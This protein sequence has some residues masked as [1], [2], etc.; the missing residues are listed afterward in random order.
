[1]VLALMEIL[2]A[3]LIVA[4]ATQITAFDKET[5]TLPF[6]AVA[7]LIVFVVK[8]GVTLLDSYVQNSWIQSLILNFK[9]RL[10]TRYTEM[11]YAYQITLNSGRS[12]SVL[13]NDADIY[14]RIGLT[15][16]GIMLSEISV[17]LILIAYLLY[18]QPAI[19]A[20][21]LIMFLI[22]GG[23]FIL[24]LVPTFRKWGKTVQE[25]AQAGYQKALQILQ[26]YKDILIFG[27][28]N[29][30]ISLYMEQ[31]ILR[32][33]VTVKSAVAQV[34]PRACIEVIFVTF[35]AG[36]VMVFLWLDYDV[37]AL[38]TVLSAYLYAGFRLLPGLN[39]MIIQL[40]NVK[41]SEASIERIVLELKS[42][43]H[44]SVYL[45]A[46]KLTFKQAINVTDV[47]FSYPKKD[48]HVLHHIDLEIKKGEFIGIVGETGSGKSTLLH[49]LLGLLLPN[50]GTVL[51]DGKYPANSPEWHS[52]IGYAAQNFHLIEGS[53]VDNVAFGVP[54]DER[55][56]ELVYKVIKNAE[57][58][59]F[60][61]KLPD[62]LD[63]QIGEKGA[64]VSG[65]ERQRIALARALY[66]Q[67][68][69]LMLDEATSALDL[70]TEKSIMNTIEHLRKED[71]TI[72]AVTHRLDTLKAADR[73]IVVE[74]GSIAKEIHEKKRVVVTR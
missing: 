67:P 54:I 22:M 59:R 31:S 47:S 15:S 12:L 74:N 35:F 20:V 23:L 66:Q 29:Y 2:A 38:T 37:T 6:L 14:M 16:A 36:L 57:L 9:K 17:F 69:I 58:G 39:R 53:V 25:T 19:T 49:L 41:M 34:L 43:Y 45:P 28:T 55:D 27:K 13:Y 8:G 60:I 51:I 44:K 30:F 62:G 7:C 1:M 21:L 46:P 73:V 52:K 4:M 32:A 5:N 10:V 56:M 26:S 68:E 61:E 71:L 63:T 42:P 11:D 24:Y 33:Q 70:E 72:I 40:N 48:V 50:E 3:S 65:G 64:M 18:L